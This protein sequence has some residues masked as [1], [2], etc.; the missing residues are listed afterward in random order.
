MATRFSALLKAYRLRAQY[1]LRQFAELIGDAPSNYANRES[2]ARGPWKDG[3]KLRDVANAL[4]LREG[5]EDW[6][7]FFFAACRP[8]TLP[9]GMQRILGRPPIPQLLRTVDELQLT[10]EQLRE[11]VEDMKKKWAKK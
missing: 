3:T 5:S 2:G 8:T 4:G 6:D 9:P 10:D 7:A 11:L 1:G